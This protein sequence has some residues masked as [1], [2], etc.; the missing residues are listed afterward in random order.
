MSHF[1]A[2]LYGHNVQVFTD[3]SAVKA[4]LE[5]PSPNDKH[6]RWW[7]KIFGSGVKNIQITYRAGRVNSNADALSRC[8]LQRETPTTSV[9]DVAVAQVQCADSDI[10]DLLQQSPVTARRNRQRTLRFCSLDSFFLMGGLPDCPDLAR[11]I[12]AQA[13]TFALVDNIVY[14]MMQR[15]TISAVPT[16]LRASLMEKNHSGPFAGHFCGEKLYKALVRHWWWP[17][18][19]SDVVGHCTNCPQCA[20]VHSSGRCTR[21]ITL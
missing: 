3:H 14:L 10:A 11:K 13:H 6:D 20:V 19:Y 7:T 4:V 1:H 16:H 17:L 9:T 21:G 12:A 18:M 15:G 8:P 5:T 2:C